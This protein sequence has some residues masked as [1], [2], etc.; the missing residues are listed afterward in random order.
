M[1]GT[2][3][4]SLRISR[5]R[6]QSIIQYPITCSPQLALRVNGRFRT[7]LAPF[8]SRTAVTKSSG[9]VQTL[10][11]PVVPPKP[12]SNV[13]SRRL[14]PNAVE[15]QDA[16]NNFW[17][18]ELSRSG[19]TLLYQARSHAGFMFASWTAGL[20]CFASAIYI[21]NQ[22]F[23]EDNEGLP[24]W[25]PF[26]YRIT[27]CFWIGIGSFAITRAHR[28][29]SSIDILPGNNQAR[30]IINV[31]RNIPL[32]YIRPR[33]LNVLASDVTLHRR[34]VIPMGKVLDGSSLT[35]S[36]KGFVLR[37]ARSISTILYNFFDG[38]RQF[39]FS[40]GMIALSIEG[41]GGTW[42]LDIY[43]Q[44]PDNAKPLHEVIRLED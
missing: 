28:R 42:K 7:L 41:Y 37:I 35:K 3:T 12:A 16:R 10:R 38:V 1:L 18:K 26:A 33:R 25:V 9:K 17:A 11:T 30:L 20:M 27:A 4:M 6:L 44:C 5:P 43:G 8:P 36:D 40:D 23:Y 15:V 39:L 32:P 24:R 31:R 14:A 22:R 29:I 2:C 19:S 34:L 21:I 13:P